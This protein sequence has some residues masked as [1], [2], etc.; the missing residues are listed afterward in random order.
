ME[1]D[2]KYQNSPLKIDFKFGKVR[3][4]L[5]LRPLS[6]THAIPFVFLLTDETPWQSIYWMGNGI[7]DNTTH[8]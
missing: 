7:L 6:Q 4:W 1:A 8:S 2:K 5:T 3:G